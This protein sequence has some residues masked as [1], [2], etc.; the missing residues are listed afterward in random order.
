MKNAEELFEGSRTYS[1][2]MDVYIDVDDVKRI[3]IFHDN[4]LISEIE[5]K[6]EG[7]KGTSTHGRCCTCQCKHFYDDDECTCKEISALT[8]I[9]NL[10]KET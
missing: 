2:G 7:L 6:I 3:L 9:I 5:K 4:E 1:N 8:E 10:I